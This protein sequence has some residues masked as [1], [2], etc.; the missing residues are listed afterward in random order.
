MGLRHGGSAFMMR[1]RAARPGIMLASC[2]AR[3]RGALRHFTE[4][5]DDDNVIQSGKRANRFELQRFDWCAAA[6]AMNDRTHRRCIGHCC[7]R[8]A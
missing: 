7:I 5:R 3:S 2:R 8:S 6:V 1:P 4:T